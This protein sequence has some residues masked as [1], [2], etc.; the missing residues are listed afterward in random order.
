LKDQLPLSI[1][2]NQTLTPKEEEH[3]IHKDGIEEEIG[4]EFMELRKKKGKIFG[5]YFHLTTHYPYV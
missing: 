2:K 3:E 1:G 5:R 4:G